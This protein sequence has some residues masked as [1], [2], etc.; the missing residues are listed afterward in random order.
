MRAPSI[1]RRKPLARFSPARTSSRRVASASD[2]K[3]TLACAKSGETST[4][5]SVIMPTRGSFSSERRMS[6]SSRWI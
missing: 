1:V 4:P 3:N 6:E 5:V 2:V